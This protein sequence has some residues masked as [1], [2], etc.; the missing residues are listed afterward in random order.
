MGYNT[1]SAEWPSIEVPEP[2]KNLVD[3]FMSLLDDSS[4]AVGDVLADEIFT[5]DAK[6]GFGSHVFEGSERRLSYM[7]HPV[8]VKL[9]I[10]TE[11][12]R[13][14]D[15]AWAVV[16]SRK[17]IILKVYISSIEANDI[18]FIGNVTMDLRNGQSPSGEFTGRLTI[19]GADTAAP[20]LKSYQVWAVSCFYGN[21][22]SDA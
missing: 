4:S 13:S 10:V 9:N 11:I 15:N 8:G 14:R 1:E 3:R 2:V 17:H 16:Q 19:S 5:S 12:R 6:A 22:L 7:C 21:S 18:L 20:K